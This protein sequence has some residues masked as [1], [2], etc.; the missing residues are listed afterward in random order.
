MYRLSHVPTRGTGTRF[1][2]NATAESDRLIH[3]RT[4]VGE[5]RKFRGCGSSAPLRGDVLE[6]LDRRVTEAC[7][8]EEQT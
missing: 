4:V 2:L 3:I 1:P 7:T 8:S 6:R 5:E